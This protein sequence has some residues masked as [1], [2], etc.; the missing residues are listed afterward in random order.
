MNEYVFI[1][2][3]K[4]SVGT[5]PP[6]KSNQNT[7]MI[8]VQ[9]PYLILYHIR[10]AHL[11]Q[12]MLPKVLY[13]GDH[14]QRTSQIEYRNKQWDITE[15]ISIHNFRV[16]HKTNSFAKVQFRIQTTKSHSENSGMACKSVHEMESSDW[17]SNLWG[18]KVELGLSCS[19][20]GSGANP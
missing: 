4:Y 6:V 13:G 10:K 7:E 8:Q 9:S 18:L 17:S 16:N 11:K 19:E 2:W 1:L 12:Q 14:K 20:M 3:G 5:I 15:L